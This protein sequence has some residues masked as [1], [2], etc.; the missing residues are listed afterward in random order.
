MRQQKNISQAFDPFRGRGTKVAGLLFEETKTLQA[1]K[2]GYLNFI[3]LC[4]AKPFHP[5]GNP[6]RLVIVATGLVG[7]K[8]TRSGPVFFLVIYLLFMKRPP[9]TINI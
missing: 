1:G 3:E 7:K 8:M 5:A 6:Q 9:H 2:A 4:S